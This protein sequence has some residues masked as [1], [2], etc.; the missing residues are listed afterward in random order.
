MEKLDKHKIK[1]KIINHA[2]KY[3][4]FK[5][6][7]MKSDLI[8]SHKV[9]FKNDKGD[10]RT[11]AYIIENKLISIMCGKIDAVAVIFEKINKIINKKLKKMNKIL[12]ANENLD[13]PFFI[14]IQSFLVCLL[15]FSLIFSI[16]VSDLIVV[17]LFFIFV[18]YIF[19]NKSFF[20][21]KLSYFKYFFAY[22]IYIVIL[23]FFRKIFLTHLNLLYLY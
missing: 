23:S 8:L 14:K 20:Y 22:W 19:K 6:L 17:I 2:S 16:F 21:F 3:I 1:Q 12:S 11:S 7:K 10:N 18:T 4:N 9:K 5:N 15:P 13:T